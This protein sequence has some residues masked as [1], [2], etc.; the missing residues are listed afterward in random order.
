[1]LRR[2]GLKKQAKSDSRSAN[3]SANGSRYATP[4][5]DRKPK[6]PGTSSPGHD[7]QDSY[8]K[9]EVK[10]E[11]EE[12]DG[13]MEED[14]PDAAAM[15]EM[16]GFSGFST[17]KVGCDVTVESCSSWPLTKYADHQNQK[18][19]NAEGAADIKKQRTWRQYMNRRGGFNRYVWR[20]VSSITSAHA[21]GPLADLWILLRNECESEFER[22]RRMLRCC[23]NRHR[24]C[25][26]VIVTWHLVEQ[27]SCIPPLSLFIPRSTHPISFTSIPRPAQS[28]RG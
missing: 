19:P 20:V 17:S 7:R 3:A 10:E 1:L 27:T 15:A 26:A 4:V 8:V 9:V 5:E 22:H 16:L 2:I 6:L 24:K 28:L 18:R 12:E 14:D 11:P 23:S 13:E 25:T 21:N